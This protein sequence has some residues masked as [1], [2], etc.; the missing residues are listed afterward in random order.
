MSYILEALKKLERERQKKRMPDPLILQG[1]A[2]PSKKRRLLWPFIIAGLILLNG[3][4]VFWLLWVDPRIEIVKIPPHKTRVVMEKATPAPQ[5]TVEKKMEQ[6][7]AEVMK[8]LPKHAPTPV[9]IKPDSSP[10]KTPTAQ[11]LPPVQTKIEAVPK[12]MKP[13]PPNGKIPSMRELPDDLRASI[14][15]IKMT[16]HSYNEKTQSRFV[17]IN[18]NM[19]REGQSIRG[20]LKVDQ[21]TQSGVILSHQGHRFFLGI[22]ETP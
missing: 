19:F 4:F 17:V 5:M 10:P 3:I 20:D 7:V 12:T 11:S 13:I 22:N 21:I 9:K 1:D 8:E 18:N 6:P 2:G 14:P 15:E 16:V